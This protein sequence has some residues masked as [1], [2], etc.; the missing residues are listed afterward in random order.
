MNTSFFRFASLLAPAI[1]AAA[2][3]AQSPAPPEPGTPPA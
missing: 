1:L 3:N 2:A